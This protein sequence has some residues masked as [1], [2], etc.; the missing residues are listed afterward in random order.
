[1]YFGADDLMNPSGSSGQRHIVSHEDA[2]VL[3]YAYGYTVHDPSV[4]GGTFYSVLDETD[5]L[6]LRGRQDAASNDALELANTIV[7]GSSKFVDTYV[8]LGNPAAGT[9]NESF[10]ARSFPLQNVKSINVVTGTALSTVNVSALFAQS[11]VAITN[12][13]PALVQIGGDT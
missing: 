12:N 6:T 9:G 8:Q 7:N 1:P 10:Y 2:L 4:F 5:T 3:Q 11:P 13:G